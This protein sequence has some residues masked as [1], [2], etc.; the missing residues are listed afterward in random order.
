MS[1]TVKI[2]GL[3]T[4]ETVVAAR[5]AGADLIGFVFVPKS[6]RAITP[7]AAAPL[8]RLAREGRRLKTVALV[9]DSDSALR[10]EIAAAVTPD[11]FQCHGRESPQEVAAIAGETGTPVI[12]ALG[13]STATDLDQVGDFAFGPGF[14]LIDA[15]PPKDAAYPGG[16][17]RPFDWSILAALDPGLPFML[18]GGL[19][20]DNV[21]EAIRTARGFGL[22]LIG[23]DVSSGVESAPGIKD[24]DR[25]RAFVAAVRRAE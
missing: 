10:R 14:V 15:K 11:F 22:N 16:H 20:P 2:C 18:S 3:R 24:I 19:S 17:G 6:P 9:V 12:R 5:D 4:P 8:A 21:G 13:V 23:V 1:L 25:I 7:E